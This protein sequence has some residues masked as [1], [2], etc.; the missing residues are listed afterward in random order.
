[1]W[2]PSSWRQKWLERGWWALATIHLENQ[3]AVRAGPDDVCGSDGARPPKE[4]LRVHASNLQFPTVI[5]GP[6]CPFNV[7]RYD[8]L[9][10]DPGKVMHFAAEAI[11]TPADA[12]AAFSS[13]RSTAGT[14]ALQG[15]AQAFLPGLQPF[16]HRLRAAS[17]SAAAASGCVR[18]EV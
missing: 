11:D 5:F 6:A 18:A 10:I 12:G 14:D 17:A 13:R 2:F 15:H 3:I 8:D 4:L 9:S 7:H 16:L 1:M